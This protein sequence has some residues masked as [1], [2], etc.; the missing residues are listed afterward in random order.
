MF[1]F[2]N[3]NLRTGGRDQPSTKNPKQEEEKDDEKV[4]KNPDDNASMENYAIT[5]KTKAL[6]KERGI[7]KLFPIQYKTFD[8]LYNGKDVVARDKT[9]S[10]KTIGYALPI[11][12]K[13][14]K[15]KH[16]EDKKRGRKP[17]VMAI[18]PT[19]ELCM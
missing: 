9:G 14:R 8:A 3:R 10:G 16:F 17:K 4:L 5:E 19:R 11:I 2:R 18:V 13:L 1:N 12:E 6:L 15:L 7:V